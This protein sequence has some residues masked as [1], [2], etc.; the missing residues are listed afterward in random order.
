M[1]ILRSQKKFYAVTCKA[2]FLVIYNI[3]KLLKSCSESVYIHYSTAYCCALDN[4]T[5]D[6]HIVYTEMT[7]TS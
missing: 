7:F 4:R 2:P 6:A 1:F 3:Y 5:H